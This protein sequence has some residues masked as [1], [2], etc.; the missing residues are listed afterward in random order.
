MLSSLFAGIS[1]LNA[2]QAAMSVIGNNIANVNT[3]GFKASR[4]S[5]S[6]ILSQNLSGGGQIGRGVKLQ[7][8]TPM[9]TQGSFQSTSS[10][11]DLAID[12]NGLFIVENASGK[13]YTRA[14]QFSFDSDGNLVSVDGSKVQGYEIDASG[15]KTGGLADISVAATSSSP[16][17]T[18]SVTMAV[19]IDSREDIPAAFVASDPEATSNFSS[20]V[21]VYDSLGTGHLSTVYFRKASEN[22][23]E[24]HALVDSGEITGGTSGT[25]E[26]TANG[27]ISFDTNGALDTETITSS[28]FDFTGGATQN[29]SISFDFGTSI[30]TDS[31]SGLDGTTQFASAS[32][33]NYQ[34]QDGYSSGSLQSI[35]INSEG[36]ITGLFSNGAAKD[37]YQVALSS[38]KSPNSL[39]S[40]GGNMFAESKDSGLPIIGVAGTAGFGKVTSSS[41][42]LSNV[43]LSQEFVNLITVQRGFQANSKIISVGDE[44]L[45]DLVNLKR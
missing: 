3:A 12:G 10:V 37:L 29:Q 17:A 7:S 6:N 35:S 9:F 4:A 13:Y 19:N 41:L 33:T 24:W 45:Q 28:G 20:S 34:D 43:D 18:S 2:H 32:S 30:T 40:I 23:W 39:T 5:F 1:G 15:N 8:V 44:L 16:K 31:G 14:G 21:T 25:M 26:E 11:T 42:E 27:T 38:F 22:N 36:V